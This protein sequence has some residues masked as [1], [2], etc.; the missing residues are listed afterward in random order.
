MKNIAQY[1]A[2]PAVEGCDLGARKKPVANW[3]RCGCA[4]AR[5]ATP[6]FLI[7]PVPALPLRIGGHFVNAFSQLVSIQ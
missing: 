5:H 3:P 2:L 4:G 6:I 7:G 1:S